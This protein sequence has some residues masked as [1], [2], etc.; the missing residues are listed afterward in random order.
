[1]NNKGFA[2]T[3]ILYTLFALFSMILLSILGN[4]SNKKTVLEHSILGLEESFKMEEKDI[5]T[6]VDDF[7][8]IKIDGKLVFKIKTESQSEFFCSTYV[9][10]GQVIPNKMPSPDF[11]FTTNECNKYNYDISLENKEENNILVLTK[12][13]ELKG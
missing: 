6:V 1:M 10:K 7:R 2:I 13:Y 12:A 3:G 8:R 4:V 11:T 9:K 5:A